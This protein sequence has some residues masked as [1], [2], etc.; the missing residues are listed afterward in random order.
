MVIQASLLTA[1]H[2]QPVALTTLTSPLPPASPGEALVGL[3]SS[4]PQALPSETTI[5]RENSEVLPLAS[6]ATAVTKLP[7]GVET[8]EKAVVKSVLPESSVSTSLEPI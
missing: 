3:S 2:E 7:A 1:I 6:L 5:A 4:V 8:G